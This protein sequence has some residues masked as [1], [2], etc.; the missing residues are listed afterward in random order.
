[1]NLPR[2]IARRIGA[3]LLIHATE[4]ESSYFE[5]KKKRVAPA[6]HGR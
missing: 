4:L 6:K 5:P 3:Y 2:N 1:V